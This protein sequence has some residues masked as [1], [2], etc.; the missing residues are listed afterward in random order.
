MSIFDFSIIR[1]LRKK[2]GI[3]AEE[4]AD[5]AGITRATV[6]K[7]EKGDGNPT[8]GTVEAI[9]RVFQLAP[10]ELVHMAEMAVLETADTRPLDM[11]QLEGTHARFPNFEVYAVSGDAGVIKE[12]EPR[13]HENTAEICMVLSGKIRL[14][15]AGR[16]LVLEPGMAVRFKALSS[17]TIEILEAAEFLLIHHNLA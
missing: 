3:T 10:S 5:Q 16:S 2:W 6:A 11:A 4:L 13:R 14:T 9:S 8:V 1:T 17:H 15:V 12:S 7:I